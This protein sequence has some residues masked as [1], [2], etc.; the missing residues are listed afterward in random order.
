MAATDTRLIV[1][2]TVWQLEPATGYA[3][4]KQLIDQGI[5]VWGGVSVASIYSVLRTLT[6]HGRLE[7][8]DDPTGVRAKTKAYRVTESGR[9]EFHALWQNAIET[10]E[11]A[12]PLAFHVAIT[13]TAFVTR[14][15]YVM[16]LRRRLRALEHGIGSPP[17][18][19]PA[20]IR[21]ALRL[22]R[23][24]AATESEWIRQTIER[25]QR[26]DSGLG[27]VPAQ[28]SPPSAA[29]TSPRHGR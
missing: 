11:P 19:V 4:R 22:W 5:D 15:T 8:I 21:N 10:I 3:V 9:R 23:Q 14:D 28:S 29:P 25:A 18:H 20:Q 16:A 12:H 17:E 6:K 13:L 26:P 2:A 27:F 1:L 7:E 24:L